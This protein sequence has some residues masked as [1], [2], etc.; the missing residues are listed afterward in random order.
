MNGALFAIA[1]AKQVHLCLSPLP[2]KQKWEVIAAPMGIPRRAPLVG[3]VGDPSS[4]ST[5]KIV[6]AG[7]VDEDYGDYHDPLAVE[8]YERAT[9]QWRQCLSLPQSLCVHGTSSAVL[10]AKFYLADC[11]SGDV[12]AFDVQTET[13]TSARCEKAKGMVFWRLVACEGGAGLLAVALCRSNEGSRVK[14]LKLDEASMAISKEVGSM[15]ADL[16]NDMFRL[17]GDELQATM[18]YAA[19]GGGNLLY[20][21][22]ESKFKDYAACA[23][24]L[25][26]ND[27]CRWS[28]LPSLPA[29]VNR[30]N[31]VICVSSSIPPSAC[32]PTSLS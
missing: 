31:R 29:P 22:T 26:K 2:L 18:L 32:F 17:E 14:L 6:V 28:K 4:P 10:G 24:D 20:V 9:R 1:G 5:H 19:S 30:F 23:C 15:P 12:C 21:Y 13:W 8:I 11:Y 25:I 7:G 3:I 27:V 16:F